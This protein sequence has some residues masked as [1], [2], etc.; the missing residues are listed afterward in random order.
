MSR[1]SR[2]SVFL[3]LLLLPIVL[4]AQVTAQPPPVS[5]E[6][7]QPPAIVTVAPTSAGGGPPGVDNQQPPVVATPIPQD[8][9]PVAV[10]PTPDAQVAPTV[11]PTATEIVSVAEPLLLRVRADLELLVVETYGAG[12]RPIGWSGSIDTSD[13]QL[14][15]LARLDL[16]IL[17]GTVYSA[18][19]RPIGWFGAVASSPYAIARDVRHDMELLADTLLGY[20][21]RPDGWLGDEPLMRCNRATQALVGVLLQGGVFAVQSDS[22]SATFC[23]DVEIEASQFVETVLLANPQ[24]TG[25]VSV[26]SNPSVSGSSTINSEFGVAFLDRNAVQR[27]GVVPNGTSFTPIGRS[28]AQFSNMMLI[29]GADYVVFVDFQFTDVPEEVFAS[30]PD[31]D[32][33]GVAPFCGASWCSAG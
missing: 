23:N 33:L 14:G 18:D 4:M 5:T 15:L 30:L 20:N 7:P 6:E 17:A 28:Y 11:E 3:L 9:P 25:D 32:T 13:P 12:E 26:V 27:V 31:V 24:F 19:E 29:Q 21:V 8:Q 22:N 2:M 16:E 10:T 1:W